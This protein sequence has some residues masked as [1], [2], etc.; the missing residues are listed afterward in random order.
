MHNKKKGKEDLIPEILYHLLGYDSN[1]LKNAGDSHCT[2]WDAEC[3]II[4]VEDRKLLSRFNS[5]AENYKVLSKFVA[6]NNSLN[7]TYNIACQEKQGLY[8]KA[9][10]NGIF[11]ATHDYRKCINEIQKD[12]TNNKNNKCI[13]FE[14]LR[15]VE[16]HKPL[17][18]TLND[19]VEKITLSQLHGGEI[20]NLMYD[21]VNSKFVDDRL[22]LTLIFKKCLQVLI[23]QL[24]TIL[25]HGV[26]FDPLKEFFIAEE[27]IGK[28]MKFKK[29][30]LVPKL[31][32]SFVSLSVANKIICM[33]EVIN[34]L[35]FTQRQFSTIQYK[36][37][38]HELYG[39][40][41]NLLFCNLLDLENLPLFTKTEFTEVIE[42]FYFVVDEFMMK[43]A[44]HENTIYNHLKLFRDFYLLGNGEFYRNFLNKLGSLSLRCDH[45]IKSIQLAFV[46]TGENLKISK[47]IWKMFRFSS[48]ENTESDD[49][50]WTKIK[51]SI[52]TK[53]PL[54]FIFTDY[55]IKNYSKLFTFLSR[56]KQVQTN[57]HKIWIEKKSKDDKINGKI[58]HLTTNLTFL[59]DTLYSYLQLDVIEDEYFILLEKLSDSQDFQTIKFIHDKFQTNIMKDSF[60]FMED[61]YMAFNQILDM[62][63]NYYRCMT[64]ITAILNPQYKICIND[65]N[66]LFSKNPNKLT[67][68]LNSIRNVNISTAPKFNQ[69]ITRL[70]FNN[71]FAKIITEK[72]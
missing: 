65:L 62:C 60:L 71:W 66:L 11:E 48:I 6:S 26:I 70:N 21:V 46:D 30:F 63:E 9:F 39:S 13:L 7:N 15:K 18:I 59:I 27:C 10:K 32:P 51:M 55:V 53:W 61:V 44:L 31:M 42:K 20:L 14:I 5:L 38:A 37:T 50:K 34:S 16:K 36:S 33:G 8:I 12:F 43:V 41:K 58:D 23:M 69:F 17:L 3:N 28:T 29:F 67:T 1:I 25:S 57:L 22:Q 68:L 47:T 49:V 45:S 54:Q 35:Q 52:E 19:L 40:K 4:N 64:D 72:Y 56:I 2:I 24:K